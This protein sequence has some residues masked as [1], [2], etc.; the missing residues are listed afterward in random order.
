LGLRRMGAEGELLVVDMLSM[1]EGWD[2]S[3]EAEDDTDSVCRQRRDLR[4]GRV[5]GGDMLGG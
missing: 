3:H 5:G 1:T 4:G 2:A